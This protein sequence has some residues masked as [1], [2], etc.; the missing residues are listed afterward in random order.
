M[1]KYVLQDDLKVFG[2]Q[3]KTFPSGIGE[4]FDSLVGM[5]PGGFNRSFYGISYMKDGAMV[6]L[7][8]AEEKDKGEAQKYDCE[9]YTVEKGEYLTKTIKDWRKKTDHIG[10]VF[11]EMMRDSRVDKTKPCVEWYKN[12]D[13]MLCMVR[14]K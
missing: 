2:V 11:H 3:V 7:A 8:A 6:Y 10:D 5:L 9:R 1:E 13:E 12:D 14:S 4:T